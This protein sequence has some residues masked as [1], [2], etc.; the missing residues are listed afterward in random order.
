MKMFWIVLVLG[1]LAAG[2]LLLAR[3]NGKP[4]HEGAGGLPNS[5]VAADQ[6]L[7]APANTPKVDDAPVKLDAPSRPE[8]AAVP[9]RV[10]S[11]GPSVAVA[12]AAPPTATAPG[13]TD[14]V[15]KRPA[16]ATK[17]GSA[18]NPPQVQQPTTPP[19]QIS[20][21]A[22][23]EAAAAAAAQLDALLGTG[24]PGGGT[25]KPV[26]PV[27]APA[28]TNAAER[29]DVA[30]PRLEA[31]DDGTTLI[32]DKYVIKGKGTQDDPYRITWELLVSTEETY[33][34]RLGQKVIPGRVKMLDGKWV[35][36]SGFVAFPIMAQ[37][38][39][40]MLMMLNQWDGCCIGVP[41]TPYDAV[42]VK[43]KTAAKGDERLRTTGTLTGVLRV[44]PY[45]V[46]EWLVSLYLM[47]NAEL[48]DAAG[49]KVAGQHAK[50]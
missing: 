7:D 34:P 37:S 40:E 5:P 13:Q 44:D 10:Q 25:A 50:P 9:T 24:E 46:K 2:A 35:R 6:R 28:A 41:P 48:T 1:V 38:A 18:Q 30:T 22:E 26:T 29:A 8:Q 21:P 17:E 33:K 43:L 45:L 15:A 14:P 20:K 42:E 11:D 31:R 27:K 4:P 3:G 23:A 39:D 12:P 47:D 16:L 36:L 32:D 49:A 19:A